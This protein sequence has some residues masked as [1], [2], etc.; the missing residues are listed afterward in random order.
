MKEASVAGES[1]D[2]SKQRES[3]EE[4]TSGSAG[5]V[6]GARGE[7]G[8]GAR[9]PRLAVARDR[10]S[11][12]RGGVDTATRVFSRPSLQAEPEAESADADADAEGGAEVDA[13]ADGSTADKATESESAA[14][15]DGTDG[16]G[17]TRLRA[18]VAAWVSGAEEGETPGKAKEAEV[19]EGAA[20]EAR[21]D[22]DAP[23]GDE[24]P[25]AEAGGDAGPGDP[26]EAADG[27]PEAAEGVSGASGEDS[28]EPGGAQESAS[29]PEGIGA[30]KP[31][32]ASAPGTGGE[33]GPASAS[34]SAPKPASA[35]E[36]E[37][38]ADVK[39]EAAVVPEPEPKP[40]PDADA[41]ESA[42]PDVSSAPDAEA[43][44]PTDSDPAPEDAPGKATDDPAPKRPLAD[45]PPT[46]RAPV[47]EPPADKAPVDEPPTDT[48]PVD[49]P[50]AIFKAPRPPAAPPV[51]QPTTM[52]KLGDVPRV[53]PKGDKRDA[54]PRANASAAAAN[55]SADAK[56][57]VEAAAE[58]NSEP[59]AERTSKFV[60]LKRLDDP[61]TRKP[62]PGAEPPSAPGAPRPKPA[63]AQPP[64]APAAPAADAT[65]AIP[66]V[67]PERTTQQ[68]LPPLPPLDLLA[69]LTNTPPPR[70]TAVR[71]IARRIK[72]WSPVAVLLAIVFA[73]VQAMRPLP[74]PELTLTAKDSYTFDGTAAALPWP[75]DGQGWM[76]VNGI[77]T[78]GKFG[79]QKPVAIGSVAKAMTAYIVLKDHPLKVGEEGPKITV[80]ATAE[81]EGGYNTDG[82]G[83]STLDTVHKGDVLT[84]KQALSAVMIPS[85]NNIARLLA[86]WDLGTEAAFIK[87][88]NATAKELGM[89]NT[90]YT[91]ASGLK[92]STLSTAEDQVKLGNQL[93]RMPALMDITRQPFWFDPSGKKWRN[94]NEV[95]PANGGIGIK[96]G[97]TSIAGGN[98][99]FAAT[100]EVGGETA[101]VV[102]AILAQHTAPII[103]TVNH[104]SKTAMIAAREA[105]LSSKILK[106]GDVVGYVDDGLGG[107]TPVVLSKDV[108][109]VGWAGRKVELSFAAASDLPHSAKAGTQVGSL[110]VGDGKSG[111]V[112]VPVQLQKDQTE[113]GFDKKLT[114]LG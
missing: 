1:P 20:D 65:A 6:P 61:A 15:A 51:D 93:V 67:G 77:G 36:A 16:T 74:A 13:D 85:A 71:T 90:V 106:K 112:K 104:V 48:P 22:A 110:T 46:D 10:E 44:A 98:L 52:L 101:I 102:G 2:R 3:S 21:P 12:A 80:D 45:E 60:A 33:A 30:A 89:K 55:A 113:P 69:E 66:Q 68:P 27:A 64:K 38:D 91:D 37:P 79:E 82:K 41:G 9:D 28:S 25:A 92:E 29:G 97:T 87:K 42:T 108:T 99:L 8:T 76:D 14:K 43:D 70:D 7:S 95:I 26:S 40:K 24:G 83:E 86:R 84:L 81:K 62:P 39:S 103:D 47:D 23:E 78:M 17:S 72:I 63:A 56:A 58:A 53:K 111:A 35:S 5:P 114:R 34:A 107:R 32:G 57:D 105:L 73:V 18:A 11:T 31:E 50:T 75:S 94:Y 54:D 49:Q 4:P 100:K 19:A 109:A 59:V 88:M 96:T